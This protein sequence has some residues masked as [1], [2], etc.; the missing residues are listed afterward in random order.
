MNLFSRSKKKGKCVLVADDVSTIRA[1]V[2]QVFRAAGYKVLE[3]RNGEEVLQLVQNEVPDLIVMDV[4]MP[5]K[6]GIEALT[7]L[8]QD[9]RFASTTV[10][11]LTGDADRDTLLKAASLNIA[12]FILRDN[13]GNVTSKLQKHIEVDEE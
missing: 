3:A 10:V 8:R 6:T 4:N 5:R 1:I 7:E 11:M 9:E 13:L 2:S 12:D